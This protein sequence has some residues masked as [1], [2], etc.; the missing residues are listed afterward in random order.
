MSDLLSTGAAWL[1]SQ[2][3]AKLGTAVTYRVTAEEVEEVTVTATWGRTEFDV[4]DGAGMKITAH[5]TDF[6]IAAA[7]MDIVPV[8]GDIILAG[9]AEYEVMNFAGEGCWRW[10]TAFRV[11]M[12]IHTR[13]TGEVDVDS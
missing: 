1:A 12:R 6:I 8:P 3:T 11:A 5:V 10:T 13:E 7:E 2:A 9:A 4:D